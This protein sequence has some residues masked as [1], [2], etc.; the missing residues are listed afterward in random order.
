MRTVKSLLY[1]FICIS[2]V[3]L[4]ACDNGDGKDTTGNFVEYTDGSRSEISSVEVDYS[5]GEGFSVAVYSTSKVAACFVPEDLTGTVF[6]L[7]SGNG[8]WSAGI[9]DVSGQRDFDSS[10][11][12]SFQSGSMY[13]NKTG[14][15][16]YEFSLSL[17]FEDKTS[18][19]V[20][21]SGRV[22]FTG[23]DDSDTWDKEPQKNS[24]NSYYGGSSYEGLTKVTV[25]D[26][27]G[28][29]IEYKFWVQD[30]TAYAARIFIPDTADRLSHYD[31]DLVD[32][33]GWEAELLG[34]D[35]K[36]HTF[37]QDDLKVTGNGYAGGMFSRVDDEYSF[38]LT[39]ELRIMDY[40]SPD[41]SYDIRVN[42]RSLCTF[43]TDVGYTNNYWRVDRLV[44]ELTAAEWYENNSDGSRHIELSGEFDGK[45]MTLVDLIIGP[46]F[47]LGN[48]VDLLKSGG[49]FWNIEIGTDDYAYLN[50]ASFGAYFLQSGAVTVSFDDTAGTLSLKMDL[51]STQFQPR[52]W[53]EGAP[54]EVYYSGKVTHLN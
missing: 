33:S 46:E 50:A 54:I 40:V 10:Y 21:F 23:D 16:Q 9:W 12:D 6:D 35:G 39:F 43:T 1:F 17:I 8:E 13:L 15:K 47:L 44:T 37:T 36:M 48:T 27:V 30:R 24:G 7:T 38:I 3:S 42:S 41:I 45:S 34:S 52:Y 28:F 11:T 25:T 22:T 32:D 49:I 51:V 19:Q 26:K 20:S 53:N 14:D 5:S 31:A 18:F 29:G 4:A 2:I